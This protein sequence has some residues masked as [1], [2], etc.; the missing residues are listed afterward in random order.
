M[1]GQASQPFRGDPSDRR[2]PDRA[3]RPPASRLISP[4]GA[5]LRF[6]LTALFEAQTRTSPGQRPGNNRPL[7][8]GGDAISWT[9]LLAPPAQRA[10]AGETYMSVAAKQARQVKSALGRLAAEELVELTRVEQPWDKY[11]KFRLLH[12]GGRRAQGPNVA[13]K[14]PQDREPVIP[15]PATL[16]SSGWIHVLEDSELTF[17]LMLAAFHHGSGGQPFKIPGE[18]RLLGY[19]NGRNTSQVHMMLERLGLVTVIPDPDRRPD[20]TV[21]GYNKGDRALLHTFS[22]HPGQFSRDALT[23]LKATI[24][25]R[26]NR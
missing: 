10:G 21:E 16:F 11:E 22:F 18:I 7:E 1:T 5:A 14:V 8:A 2:L 24:D 26:L 4:R 9:D 23:E 6:Y 25:R 19:G 3:D 13:Y 20:G 15:M 12:E 17:L